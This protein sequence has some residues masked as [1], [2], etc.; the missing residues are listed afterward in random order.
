M[1]HIILTLTMMVLPLFIAC[2]SVASPLP[3]EGRPE[4]AAVF[5]R[6]GDFSLRAAPGFDII[7]R[8]WDL[9]IEYD[10][11]DA[12][13]IFDFHDAAFID[14]GF[15]RVSF[16]QDIPDNE[17]EAEYR[18]DNLEIGLEV[19]L[20]DGK[21]EV[22]IDITETASFSREPFSLE[23]FAGI[24]IPF[25]DAPFI[26]VDWEIE[27][28]YATRDIDALYDYYDDS[29]LGLGWQQISFERDGDEIDADYEKD[30]VKLELEL[31]LDDNR[32]EVEI[33]I[34]KDRFY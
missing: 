4:A 17:F 34:D 20:D 23:R 22:E 14:Q 29:L 11:R 32:V 1:K 30:G 9:D 21:V 5:E 8:E 3:S 24:E 15:S 28:D 10:S 33:E 27:T 13:T 18:R 7:E 6:V 16:E 19:E 26:E 2:D 25:Y 12:S 31:E